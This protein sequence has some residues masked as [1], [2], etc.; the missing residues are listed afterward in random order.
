MYVCINACMYCV[1]AYSPASVNIQETSPVK[2][3]YCDGNASYI[4]TGVGSLTFNFTNLRDNI[5]FYY[6]T[7]GSYDGCNHIF[8]Y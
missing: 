3:G 7:A 2:W 1:I 8:T 4:P 5:A 6:F